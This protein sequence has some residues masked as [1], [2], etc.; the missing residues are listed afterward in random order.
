MTT[1]ITDFGSGTVSR[2]TNPFER[3]MLE[4]EQIQRRLEDGYYEDYD[5]TPLPEEQDEDYT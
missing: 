4:L 1:Y 3:D 5:D 2:D